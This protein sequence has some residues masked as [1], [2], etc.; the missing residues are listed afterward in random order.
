M[1]LLDL[2]VICEFYD[3]PFLPYPFMYTGPSPFTSFDEAEA[4]KVTVPDRFLHGDLRSFL[5]CTKAY[6]DP[7]IRVACHVQYIPAD[8][9]SVRLIAWRLGQLGFFAAQRPDEDVVDIHTVSPYEL[10]AAVAEAVPLRGPGRHS[11]IV[12]PEYVPPRPAEFDVEDFSVNHRLASRTEVTIPSREVT[13]Y[14]TVQ[15]HWRPPLKWGLDLS[16]PTL[17]WIQVKDDGDYVYAPDGSHARPMTRVMLQD[18]IDRLI[19]DDIAILREFR[20]D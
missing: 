2:K 10:G 15:S 18:R 5:E 3:R 1:S 9:S 20:R 6:L 11:A 19:A 13:V 16:T 17:V 8:T 12:V 4:Y 7:D 14:S